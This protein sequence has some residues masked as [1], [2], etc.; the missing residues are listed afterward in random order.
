MIE[1]DYREHVED[2]CCSNYTLLQ[3]S[4][5]AIAS[6]DLWMI[7]KQN[8]HD[9][10]PKSGYQLQKHWLCVRLLIPCLAGGYSGGCM[11]RDITCLVI[12]RSLICV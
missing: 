9:K 11:E 2:L 12:L 8:Y 10:W 1:H 6:E 5:L 4:A 3:V 7:H